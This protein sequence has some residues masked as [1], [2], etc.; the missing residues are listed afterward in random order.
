M[1]GYF[2]G[3]TVLSLHCGSSTLYSRVRSPA[4][5]PYDVA[6]FA[7]TP[8][9]LSL[10][11]NQWV[12]SFMADGAQDTAWLTGS[13]IENYYID[14]CVLG[15]SFYCNGLLPSLGKASENTQETTF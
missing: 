2:S 1:L 9:P 7:W 5:Q 15:S 14:T 11:V 4:L 12:R 3:G 10:Y 13:E 6:V 8:Q